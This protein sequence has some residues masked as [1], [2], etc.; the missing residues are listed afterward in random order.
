MRIDVLV[1]GDSDLYTSNSSNSKLKLFE[2]LCCDLNVKI[3][4]NLE[5]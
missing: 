4:D 1:V 3:V 5:Q 2:N